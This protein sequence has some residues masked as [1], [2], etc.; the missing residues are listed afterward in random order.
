[1]SE[2]LRLYVGRFG[3]QLCTWVMLHMRSRQMHECTHNT[4]NRVHPPSSPSLCCAAQAMDADRS[5]WDDQH[6]QH[7]CT[8]AHTNPMRSFCAALVCSTHALIVCSTCSYRVIAVFCYS[9]WTE[10]ASA[11]AHS[12]YAHAYALT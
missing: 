9:A 1:M 10:H 6:T 11:Q 8:H 7:T 5:F 2:D 4:H 3:E 12:M